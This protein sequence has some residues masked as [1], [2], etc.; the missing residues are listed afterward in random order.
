M[1]RVLDFGDEVLTV[2]WTEKDGKVTVG[3]T[4]ILLKSYYN[5][6]MEGSKK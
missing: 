2:E 1:I 4:N 5:K 3:N 6:I